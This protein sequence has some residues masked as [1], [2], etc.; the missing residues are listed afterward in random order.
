[1]RLGV[2]GAGH[3]YTFC[4]HAYCYGIMLLLLRLSGFIEP[5]LPSFDRNRERNPAGVG[6]IHVSTETVGELCRPRSSNACD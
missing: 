2:T 1:V 3:F 6:A 5:C 4:V